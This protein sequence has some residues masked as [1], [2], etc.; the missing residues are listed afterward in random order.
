S[1]GRFRSRSGSE[2]LSF[3]RETLLTSWAKTWCGAAGY[4]AHESAGR[5]TKGCPRGAAARQGRAA[6]GT[7]ATPAGNEGWW[8]GWPGRTPTPKTCGEM[9]G[10]GALVW[11]AAPQRFP[12]P[13]G[14]PA[15]SDC[16]VLFSIAISTDG[17]S[18]CRG[19]ESPHPP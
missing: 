7:I 6:R 9:R 11:V 17:G 8:N 15:P 13:W 18:E 1:R 4:A 5:G 19:F 16:S 12:T 10:T 2:S 3:F 14:A